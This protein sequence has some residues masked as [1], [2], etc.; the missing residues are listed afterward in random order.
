MKQCE[1]IQMD[2]KI[3]DNHY[4]LFLELVDIYAYYSTQGFE[5]YNELKNKFN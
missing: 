4:S 2:K 1:E 3:K 5:K